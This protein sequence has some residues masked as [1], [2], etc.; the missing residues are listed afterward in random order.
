MNVGDVLVWSTN[1][2]IGYKSRRKMHIFIHSGDWLEENIFLFISSVD[3]GGDYPIMATRY[4]FLTH[5]S[6]VSCG[7]LTTYSDDEISASSPILQGRLLLDDL[8]GL[9]DAIA[10]SKT[11]E[12]RHIPT[13][14]AAIRSALD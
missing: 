3:Y 6:F 7:R 4:K 8:T 5:D 13:I 14:C 2:A 11:M 10:K 1:K 12:R 9:H